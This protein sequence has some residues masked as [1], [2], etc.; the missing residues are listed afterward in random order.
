MKDDRTDACEDEEVNA[1]DA[2]DA[3]DALLLAR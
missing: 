2:A 3:M 1:V